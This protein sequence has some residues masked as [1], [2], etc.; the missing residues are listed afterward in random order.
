MTNTKQTFSGDG[1][2]GDL[3]RVIEKEENEEEKIEADDSL[4]DYL[5]KMPEILDLEYLVEQEKKQ[6][7]LMN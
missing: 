3:E 7:N 2:I 6:R 4:V 1:L 5:D